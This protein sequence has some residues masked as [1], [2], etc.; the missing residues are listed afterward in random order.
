MME[1]MDLFS[2]EPSEVWV[3]QV[4]TPALQA[5]VARNNVSTEKLSLEEYKGY[6]SV[7]Y[8]TQLA[9]RIC[10]RKNRSYFGVSNAYV[11]CASPE[12][13]SRV[14][15]TGRSEGFTNYSFD[16][17]EEGIC[18][19]SDFL[20]SVLDQVIDSIPKEF[21]CCSRYEECSNAKHCTNPNANIATGCGYRKILKNGTI[22][23]G[24]NRNID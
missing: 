7:C 5:V 20:A 9:F 1:Q 16:P 3:Y 11:S 6:S 21:D 14:T 8:A 18:A 19:F 24:V 13:S 10:C 15:K 12:I 2:V 17:T 4:L 22:F 23:Y